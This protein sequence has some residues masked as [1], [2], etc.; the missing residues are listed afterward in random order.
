LGNVGWV[1]LFS[2]PLPG[3]GPK[4]VL[5]PYSAGPFLLFFFPPS[6]PNKN[7]PFRCPNPPPKNPLWGFFW[8]GAPRFGCRFWAW[9]GNRHYPP[10]IFGFSSVLYAAFWPSAIIPPPHTHLASFASHCS[11]LGFSR[12]PGFRFVVGDNVIFFFP[13]VLFFFLRLVFF[14]C[15]HF[16]LGLRRFF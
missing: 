10:K 12:L 6:P 3:V 8:F 5:N 9:G 14:V 13:G 7:G 1:G 4:R 2:P 15:R 16:P 11:P